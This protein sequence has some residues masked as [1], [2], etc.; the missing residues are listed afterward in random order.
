MYTVYEHNSQG[1]RT[2][3]VFNKLDIIE[4]FFWGGGVFNLR[5]LQR[6]E[7]K[8]PSSTMC[9]RGDRKRGSMY[10]CNPVSLSSNSLSYITA[11]AGYSACTKFCPCS[12]FCCGYYSYGYCYC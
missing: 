6:L 3:I 10:H 1:S 7:L 11:K 8:L 9:R 2:K 4:N 12:C 5:F